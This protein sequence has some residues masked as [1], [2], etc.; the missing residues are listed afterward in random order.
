MTVPVGNQA[1]KV[2]L[3]PSLRH[4][5]EFLLNRETSLLE[6]FRRVL[7]EAQDARQPPLE[8]L[9]FIAIFSSNLDEFF[10]IR[11]SGIKE[12]LEQEVVAPTSDG[13]A[14]E[15]QLNLIRE[16]VLPMVAEQSRCLTEEVL[17]QLAGHGIEIASY[18]S[19]SADERMGLKGYFD[20]H[21]FPVLTPQG[22]DPGHPFPYI[23]NLSLN[24]GLMVEPAIEHGI[25]RSLTGR[26][27][28]RFVRIK[29]PPTVPRLVRV[30]R[31][32]A[33]FVLLED[34]IAG[35]AGELFQRMN[36]GRCHT[37]RVTRDAD[38]EV[39][40]YEADDLLRSMEQTLR[41]R[42]FGKAVRLEV[43]DQMPREMVDYLATELELEPEDVYVIAGP[44]GVGDLMQL[45][46]LK[47][48]ELKDKPLASTTPAVLKGARSVFD[49][50]RARDVLLHHPYTSYDTV[51]DF[52]KEAARDPDVVAIKMCLYR[53]GQKSP[54]PK[55]LIE[56]S[57]RG[58]QVTALVELKAR[59][60]EEANI[61]WAKK[62]EEA[63][64]HVIY[65]VLGL[66]THCKVALIV[67]REGEGLRRYVHV[68]TGNYNP[69]TSGVYTDLGLLTADEEIGEDASDLFNFLTGFSRQKDYLKLLV[70]PANL[71]ERM[72]A[73]INRERDNQLAGKPA[74][75]GAKVNRVAD[76]EIIRAL[77]EA[78][79]AGVPVD[80]VVRGVCMLK[81]GVPGLSE[82]IRVRSVVGRL[83]EH[84]R[85][86]HFA[87]GG[88]DEIYI[89]SSDWMTRNLDRRVEVVA[90]VLDPHLRRYLKDVVLD[91]YLRDNA[92]TRELRPDG[93][94]E[95]VRPAPGEEPFDSQTH[96]EG[97]V[98]LKM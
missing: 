20:E 66:K 59:F 87:N 62:L 3:P 94:Y 70:A 29:V 72:T 14:P 77:Y 73:L 43:S 47:R 7:E 18:D 88:D 4:S 84:S 19:L 90:P 53:T 97:S 32:G 75:I 92:N 9:K 40:D 26:P 96:F 80:L 81:P 13:L 2:E 65:G 30:G 41:K 50:V 55:A 27:E 68:A 34:V 95:R 79:Q 46:V 22:V 76:A 38:I 98:S 74:R 45:Y 67:R 15:E 82:T 91:A 5:R 57:E 78:S 60:D 89:G 17:P 33:R 61:G 56:A 21:V 86:F 69:V 16:Y 44:L 85:I 31:E 54:I 12:E 36:A 25:T 6:F 8:R 83:L 48:P 39:R 37:F 51:V 23:S 24:I 63:G 71:R 52:M 28:P 49:V 10:M 93:S 58:K 11:V 35:N 64:V 1:A 42:R